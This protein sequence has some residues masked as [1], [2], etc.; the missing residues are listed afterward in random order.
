[1]FGRAVLVA[2][3][4]TGALVG[5]ITFY[6]CEATSGS[7][8]YDR[9]EVSSFGQFAVE[10]AL[11]RTGLGSRLLETVERRALESGAEELALDTAEGAK[12]LIAIYQRRG[13]RLV[14]NADWSETN[15]QSVIL[16]K[17]L[18]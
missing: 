15:Y 5:T 10:P 13:Y 17:R 4:E 2:V 11:Q 18:K 1:M 12:H 14:G 8:W 7:A 6:P 9:P 3:D 16:S